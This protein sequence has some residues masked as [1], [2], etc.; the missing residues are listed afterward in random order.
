MIGSLP[1]PLFRESLV[2]LRQRVPV[3]KTTEPQ[4]A[5]EALRN[6][7]RAMYVIFTIKK[8]SLYNKRS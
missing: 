2:E 8:N 3:E 5:S 7:E 4:F 1:T 6:L